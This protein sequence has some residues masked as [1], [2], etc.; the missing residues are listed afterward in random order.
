MAIKLEKKVQKVIQGFVW[1]QPVKILQ[2]AWVNE[3][4][5]N[6]RGCSFCP[7]S[8]G[9]SGS[10]AC[11]QFFSQARSVDA[12]ADVC[13]G[14]GR[15]FSRLSKG[16]FPRRRALGY[17]SF[18]LFWGY[19]FGWIMNVWTWTAFIYPLSWQT[20]LAVYAASAWFDTLHAAGNILFYLFLGPGTEKVFRRVK[21]RLEV[22]PLQVNHID[23]DMPRVVPGH[24][25]L[26][27]K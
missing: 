6:G 16:F 27:Q 21:K 14:A 9:N 25:V 3:C 8:E 4:Y 20:F 10:R 2:A 15:L 24:V 18:Q 26:P 19:A 5:F 17:D 7:C 23:I 11:F 1:L 22:S 12:L 13:L